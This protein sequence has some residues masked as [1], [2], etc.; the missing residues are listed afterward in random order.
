MRD[1]THHCRLNYEQIQKVYKLFDL[2]LGEFIGKQ[3]P[4]VT[5]I[6]NF[7]NAIVLLMKRLEKFIPLKWR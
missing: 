1:F 5:M 3:K 4:Q 2:S 6:F 7:E